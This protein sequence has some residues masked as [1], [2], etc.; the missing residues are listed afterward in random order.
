MHNEIYIYDGLNQCYRLKD[1]KYPD[2]S[3]TKFSN[4]VCQIE[5]KSAFSNVIWQYWETHGQK[6]KYIDGLY[7]IAKRNS[8]VEVVRVVPETL[9]SYLPYISDNVLKIRDVAHKADMI[10]S[11]LLCEYGGMWLDSDAVV[12]K[13]L[14]FLFQLLHKFDFVGFNDRGKI[15]P[16]IRINC[17]LARAGCSVMKQWVRAQHAKFPRTKF[18]WS[19]IGTAL[20]GPI[21]VRHKETVKVLPFEFVCPVPWNKFNRFYAKNIDEKKLTDS[22]LIVM[23]QN[24]T[25]HDKRSPLIGMTVEEITADDYLISK[26]LRNAMGRKAS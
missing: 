16:N 22:A 24:R 20:L 3:E 13:N 21:C 26:I 1:M 11:L 10:R 17:F 6:P 5:L 18:K 9:H 4:A 12:L 23:L 25:M 14:Q 8:G 2:Q 19:E 7:E 15:S